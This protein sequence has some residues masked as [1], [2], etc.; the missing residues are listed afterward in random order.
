MLR[1]L[2]RLPGQGIWDAPTAAPT[3]DLSVHL[4]GDDGPTRLAAFQNLISQSGKKCDIVISAMLTGALDGTDEWRA[5]CA[6]GGTWAVW[7]KAD[8]QIEVK[9]CS[10]GQCT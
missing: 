6:D 3:N 1:S 9:R 5:K 4:M 7:F 8:S 10:T 2:R